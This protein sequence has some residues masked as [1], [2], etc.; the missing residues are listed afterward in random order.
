[1]FICNRWYLCFCHR[2]ILTF[3]SSCKVGRLQDGS[4]SNICACCSS[5]FSR[6]FYHTGKPV[7]PSCIWPFSDSFRIGILQW[8]LRAR[9]EDIYQHDTS[10]GM[11]GCS[12][13]LFFYRIFIRRNEEG[14]LC[15]VLDWGVFHR[16]NSILVGVHCIRNCTED[17]SSWKCAE[18]AWGVAGWHCESILWCTWGAWRCSSKCRSRST[19]FF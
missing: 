9:K 17:T 10:E 18:P 12:K 1:M 19:L 14:G 6:I 2:S 13:C 15:R 16:N 11:D 7:C 4:F 8:S 5:K 3:S